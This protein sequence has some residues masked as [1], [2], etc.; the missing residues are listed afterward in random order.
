MR[1]TRRTELL[2]RYA[3]HAGR[4][5]VL[6]LERHRRL[7]PSHRLSLP[8]WDRQIGSTTERELAVLQLVADGLGNAEIGDR[9]YIS[10]ETVKSHIRALLGKLEALNRAHA[11]AIGLGEG[12][13]PLKR[14]AHALAA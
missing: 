14:R 9:L 11:V 2:R 6:A 5:D 4:F 10:I 8:G 1:N 7:G 3:V 13:I 12:L